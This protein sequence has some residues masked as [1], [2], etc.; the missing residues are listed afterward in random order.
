MQSS[1]YKTS[2]S[3]GCNIVWKLQLTMSIV[4]LKVAKTGLKSSQDKKKNCSTV[5]GDGC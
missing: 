3:W 1:G 2:K 4:Y 5:Y